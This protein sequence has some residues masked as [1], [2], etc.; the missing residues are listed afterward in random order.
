MCEKAVMCGFCQLEL[1]NMCRDNSCL[2]GL[3]IMNIN[4]QI[5]HYKGTNV[6]GSYEELSYSV[7]C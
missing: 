7:Y 2:A 1:E 6:W 4:D 5:H 3:K